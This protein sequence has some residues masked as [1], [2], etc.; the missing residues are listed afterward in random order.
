[1]L[2]YASGNR[3]Q[4]QLYMFEFYQFHLPLIRQSLFLEKISLFY[5]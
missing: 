5:S 1:M 3:S 2:L 4:L